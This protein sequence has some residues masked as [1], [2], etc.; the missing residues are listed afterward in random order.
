MSYLTQRLNIKLG[1]TKNPI[2]KK[3][4][5]NKVSKK[6]Q[7]EQRIYKKQVIKAINKDNKCKIKSPDCTGFAQGLD[8]VQ[9]RSP[10]NFLD[11]NN[12]VPACNACN[13]YKELNVNWAIENGHSISRF[14]PVAIV[15]YDTELNTTIIEPV[16]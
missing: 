8:H 15:S 13:F 2:K 4:A 9:K 6:R 7:K 10:K 12:Q 16:K 14:K 1:L 3:A 5:I 11:T